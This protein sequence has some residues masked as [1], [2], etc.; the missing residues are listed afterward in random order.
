LSTVPHD[1]R[2]DRTDLSNLTAHHLSRLWPMRETAGGGA[3]GVGVGGDPW[4]AVDL[5]AVLRHQLD[6]PLAAIGQGAVAAAPGGPATFGSVLT[7]PS[8][9]VDLLRRVKEWAKVG[10]PWKGEDAEVPREVCGV[11]YFAANAAAVARLG[12]RIGALGD[13]T[14]ANGA[15]W[16]LT[17]PWLDQRL[18]SVFR[19]ALAALGTGEVPSR[20]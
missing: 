19:E 2:S 11:L 10:M 6:A 7:H 18:T 16:A 14:L 15:R 20:Q 12:E 13:G 5:G 1:P 4:Y 17:R 3:P 8:P 9:P